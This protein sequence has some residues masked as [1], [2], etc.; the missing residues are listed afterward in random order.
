MFVPF[1]L[2]LSWE[3]VTRTEKASISLRLGG[4]MLLSLADVRCIC[5]IQVELLVM[6]GQ[7]GFRTALFSSVVT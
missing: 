3:I 5:E 7:V 4:F 6:A 2:M 1:K